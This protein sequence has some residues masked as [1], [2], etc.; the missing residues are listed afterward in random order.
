MWKLVTGNEMLWQRDPVYPKQKF[1]G[2][3]SYT[4]DRVLDLLVQVNA[5]PPAGTPGASFTAGDVFAGYLM[6]DAWIG[7][8]DRHHENWGVLFQPASGGSGPELAPSYDHAACLGQ[9]LT[10]RERQGR[11]ESRD[12]GFKVE[13]WVR[14]GRGALY[15][16]TSDPKP[17]S[18]LEAFRRARMRYPDGAGMWLE[19]LEGLSRSAWTDVL[20]RLPAPVS[21]PAR[22][23]ADEVLHLNRA[24]LL[25]PASS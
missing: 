22:L 24:R 5:R 15:G 16:D 11:L 6:F 17:L 23:F 3:Q 10:D 19:R 7:N 13:A 21:D 14:K 12:A 2:V 9:T 1:R 18:T 20:D 4:V 8:Q 25:A